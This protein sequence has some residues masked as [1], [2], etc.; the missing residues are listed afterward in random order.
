M[1]IWIINQHNKH[2]TISYENIIPE[3]VNIE[4]YLIK[5]K[6]STDIFKSDIII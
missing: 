3:I 1:K 2:D 5:L 6:N 4:N